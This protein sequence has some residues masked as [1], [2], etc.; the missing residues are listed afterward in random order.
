MKKRCVHTKSA[1]L[2]CCLVVVIVI[3]A[4]PAVIHQRELTVSGFFELSEPTTIEVEQLLF[5]ENSFFVTNG[6]PLKLVVEK[7]LLIGGDG[8]SIIGLRSTE[9]DKC[10]FN[11]SPRPS[12]PPSGK[13]CNPGPYTQG[14]GEGRVGRWGDAGLA[15]KGGLSR[16]SVDVGAKRQKAVTGSESYCKAA[17]IGSV[18]ILIEG[19]AE[20]WLR[21]DLQ[22][23]SGWQVPPAGDGGDGGNGQQGGK[24]ALEGGLGGNG[25]EGGWSFPFYYSEH[26]GDGG[27]FKLEI[28]GDSQRFHLWSVNTRAGTPG[29]PGEPGR[30]GV[31]GLGGYWGG[32]SAGCF[33]KEYKRSPPGLPGARGAVSNSMGATGKDGTVNIKGTSAARSE[34][35]EA[36]SVPLSADQIW[37]MKT[38]FWERVAQS[39]FSVSPTYVA[40][41]GAEHPLIL[42]RGASLAN[43]LHLNTGVNNFSLEKK[44]F[45]YA[46]DGLLP[47]TPSAN[48]DK[49]RMQCCDSPRRQQPNS[50]FIDCLAEFS[51]SRSQGHWQIDRLSFYE[52]LLDLI[53]QEFAKRAAVV[54]KDQLGSGTLLEGHVYLQV[55][56][57]DGGEDWPGSNY[58]LVEINSSLIDALSHTMH[59]LLAPAAASAFVIP[60]AIKNL[61]LFCAN[62]RSEL[63]DE[64]FSGLPRGFSRLTASSTTPLD[65]I[66]PQ[67]AN[68]RASVFTAINVDV[69]DDESVIDLVDTPRSAPAT[70]AEVCRFAEAIV[71]Q[72]NSLLNC[73]AGFDLASGVTALQD[74]LVDPELQAIFFGLAYIS[75]VT[76]TLD[77]NGVIHSVRS[78]ALKR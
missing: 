12:K 21:V 5:S 72:N 40:V 16:F 33:D 62:G 70:A 14:A 46:K 18:E 11:D 19:R 15:G 44:V 30:G 68:A 59:S 48:C 67:S 36:P 4:Y 20:G 35:S 43:L 17:S 73:G 61:G 47:P 23:G 39:A 75:A 77:A 7:S 64:S 28:Q 60:T 54:A 53:A 55:A 2:S 34:C 3:P 13:C 45:L 69:Y 58:L 24:C 74:Q 32:G 29:L 65:V 8:A 76:H 51:P 10:K 41:A 50:P 66:Q 38:Q 9:K 6:F 57:P 31:P 42:L 27:N 49:T 52:R 71:L 25:G 37:E 78:D 26:S 63:L 1:L 22:G 56:N